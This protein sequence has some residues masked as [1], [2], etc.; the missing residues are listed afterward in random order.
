MLEALLDEGK[1][2]LQTNRRLALATSH[3]LA[4]DLWSGFYDGI[5][6]SPPLQ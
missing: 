2:L 3:G 4:Y 5:L 6:L 1:E